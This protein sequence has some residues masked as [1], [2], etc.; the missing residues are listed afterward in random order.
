MIERIR[1]EYGGSDMGL[2]EVSEDSSYRMGVEEGYRKG[3]ADAMREASRGGSYRERMP[4]DSYRGGYRMPGNR[5]D[6]DEMDYD[7]WENERR[8][9]DSRGRYM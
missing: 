3:Y 1:D 6:P 5:I 7:D 9:R 4:R 8:R 2:R